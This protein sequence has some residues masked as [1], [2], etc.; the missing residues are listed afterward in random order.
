ML[1]LEKLPTLGTTNDRLLSEMPSKVG[2]IGGVQFT[3]C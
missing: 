3:M 1:S 2:G